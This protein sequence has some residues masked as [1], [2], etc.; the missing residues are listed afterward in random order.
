MKTEFTALDIYKALEIRRERLR[1]WLK[2]G[3]I[4]LTLPPVGQGETALYTLHD[5]YGIML[6]HSLL[7]YGFSR[8]VAGDF[9]NQLICNEKEN[10]DQPKADYL[11]LRESV[12]DEGKVRKSI[13]AI[14]PGNRKINLETGLTDEMQYLTKRTRFRNIPMADKEYR[15]LHII[16]LGRLRKEVDT[17]LAKL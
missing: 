2:L 6:F 9:V 16:N 14:E 12:N 17:A 5:V 7:E 4:T 11:L 15:S 13:M 8:V 1:S 3:F 10:S